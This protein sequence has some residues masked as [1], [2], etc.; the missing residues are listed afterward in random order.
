MLSTA[1]TDSAG[2]R[3]YGMAL[4]LRD[5][6]LSRFRSAGLAQQRLSSI[7][8]LKARIST[9]QSKPKHSATATE[10]RP[11]TIFDDAT[12]ERIPLRG[13]ERMFS[14]AEGVSFKIVHVMTI[15]GGEDAIA[16]YLQHLP[17]AL[18]LTFNRHP[19]MRALQV[20]GAFAT[21]EIQPKI[22]LDTVSKKK[23]LDIREVV[24]T[25]ESWEQY[26]ED[27]W[28]I[29]F[30]RCTELPF[31]VRVWH[32]PGQNLAR[33]MLFC[34]HYMSDGI[35][36]MVIL[37][38]LVTFA[39]KLSRTQQDPDAYKKFVNLQDELP[40]RPPL[41]DMWLGPSPVKSTVKN[42][43][44]WMLGWRIL[45]HVV[46]VFRP[47]IPLRDD[48]KDL[49]IP[50]KP[51]SS[52]ALFGLGTAE[53]LSK[54]LQRC[55]EEGVTFFCAVTA[56]VVVSFYIASDAEKRSASPFKLTL[57][58]PL[59]MRNRVTLPA[60]EVQVG[61]YTATNALESF[62]QEGVAMDSV[63]FWDLARK[64]KDELS[65]LMRNVM[66]SMPYLFLDNHMTSNTKPSFFNGLRVPHS[67]TSDVDVSNIGKYGY[68]T[69]HAFQTGG[70][71]LEELAIDCVHVSNSIP[72][73][74]SAAAIYLA[75]T[76]K[77]SY[78]FM[79]KYEDAKGRQLFNTMVASIESIGHVG[80]DETMIDVVNALDRAL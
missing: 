12:G 47:I 43:A 69:K 28:H 5:K 3:V 60:P 79:H 29:P 8:D 10:L 78:G 56:A 32:Y 52:S 21:A 63:R 80:S 23:L 19:R 44:I 49:S 17:Q 57:E 31:Y 48:Q 41:S 15:R 76:D 51:N 2:K 26:A 59:N 74:G 62:A 4:H 35:S 46:K 68:E 22:T 66:L 13:Y 11:S 50:I 38:N 75:S 61:T 39:S 72:Q 14:M 1:S 73:I 55:K 27:Q 64:S 65:A 77:L 33:V 20:R 45:D 34:D 7:Y 58:L 71:K 40:L 9:R 25:K 18:V 30:D 67:I 70:D 53:N 42:Y 37:N 36:G 24:D 6:S 16:A 54:A